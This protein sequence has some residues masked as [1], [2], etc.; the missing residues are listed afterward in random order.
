MSVSEKAVLQPIDIRTG[1]FPFSVPPPFGHGL[2]HK[3]FPNSCA[4]VPNEYYLDGNGRRKDAHGFAK[5][6]RISIR[7]CPAPGRL[8]TSTNEHFDDN[9]LV[10]ADVMALI[11]RM[12]KDV[13]PYAFNYVR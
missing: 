3:Q 11:R 7:D 10:D 13:F 6:M 12:L 5:N 9:L 4:F 8:D 2:E 1:F